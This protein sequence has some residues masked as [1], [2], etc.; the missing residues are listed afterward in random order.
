[1]SSDSATAR[2]R[3]PNELCA[4]DLARAAAVLA[5]FAFTLPTGIALFGVICGAFWVWR[6]DR[7][8]VRLIHDMRASNAFFPRPPTFSLPTIRDATSPRAFRS[9]RYAASIDLS[10]AYWHLAISPRL[11]PFFIL[12]TAHSIA[13][14]LFCHRALPFGWSWSPF[15]FQLVLSPIIAAARAS[16]IWISAYL[17]DILILGDTKEECRAAWQ[18]V[19]DLL[20]EHG[21]NVN[22]KKSTPPATSIPFLGVV[23]H[24]RGGCV[25]ASWPTA[26]ATKVTAQID[27]ALASGVISSRELASICG[28]AAFLRVVAPMC[29]FIQRPLDVAASH[30][31]SSSRPQPISADLRDALATFR[32]WA[33][34]LAERQFLVHAP[35][36]RR[37]V[38]RVDSSDTGTGAW[39]APVGQPLQRM[40]PS[41]LPHELRAT[42]SSSREQYGSVVAALWCLSAMH[43]PGPAEPAHITIVCDNSS[44]GPMW[45]RGR[46]TPDLADPS[47]RMFAA[48]IGN[49]VPVIVSVVQVP[50][51]L[52]SREDADSRAAA[53]DPAESR[54]ARVDDFLSAFG[55]RHRDLFASAANR[56]APLHASL[57]PE[58]T[59]FA[60][61]GLSVPLRDGDHAFPPTPLA[62]RFLRRVV[63][64]MSHG[65]PRCIDLT[66]VVP[67]DT[68]RPVSPHVSWR[69]HPFSFG[70][71][72]PP[73]FSTVRDAE[74]DLVVLRPHSPGCSC[75]LVHPRAPEGPS[76]PRRQQSPRS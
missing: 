64:E 28:R 58:P 35:G 54:I 11:W 57:L 32:A 25:F 76:L 61:D 42:S 21:W 8:R 55:P 52:L 66:V 3:P 49:P 15:L 53:G 45:T 65:P 13:S 18:R 59:A 68:I 30:L 20:R 46:T 6:S 70:L 41:A 74:S 2:D 56:I 44:V 5:V 51:A 69:S 63:M 40:P 27:A 50:R 60:I 34:L 17:D 10:N 73:D 19:I 72:P 24:L 12:R 9:P 67:R 16:G 47:H 75:P 23:L 31:A 7:V 36:A 71:A 4:A 14:P 43:P 48:L 33:P 26:K 62:Q 1:M 29:G 37:Y 39:A 22:L 38:V